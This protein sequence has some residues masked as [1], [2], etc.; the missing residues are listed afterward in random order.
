MSSAL[1]PPPIGFTVTTPSLSLETLSSVTLNTKSL[2]LPSTALPSFATILATGSAGLSPS[3]LFSGGL[4]FGLSGSLGSN[5]GLFGSCGAGLSL[6]I[7]SALLFTGST[8]TFTAPFSSKPSSKVSTFS[9]L[10]SSFTTKVIGL[11]FAPEGMQ[12]STPLSKKFL[13]SL[14]SVIVCSLPSLP[15]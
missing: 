10:A 13:T 1:T 12:T 8:T 7:P 11:S 4:L 2:S 3:V 9:Y 5:G 6:I 14:A 15:I